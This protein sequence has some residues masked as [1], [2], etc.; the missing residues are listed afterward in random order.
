MV[1][2]LEDKL[3][4]QDTLLTSPSPLALFNELQQTE[5]KYMERE[6]EGKYGAVINRSLVHK[7]TRIISTHAIKHTAGIHLEP[8]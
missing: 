5:M 7:Q 8:G 4:P 3:P 6:A 2:L 1:M